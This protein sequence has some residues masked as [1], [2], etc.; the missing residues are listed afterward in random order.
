MIGRSQHPNG[1]ERLCCADSLA[2]VLLTVHLCHSDQLKRQ[3]ALDYGV[4]FPRLNCRHC[5]N[6]KIQGINGALELLPTSS[7]HSMAGADCRKRTPA[8][9][10]EED[11]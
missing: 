2:T 10:L 1:Q 8:L 3:V 11:A 9:P 5:V 6:G 4:V 7:V